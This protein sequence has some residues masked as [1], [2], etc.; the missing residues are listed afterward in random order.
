VWGLD[1]TL[2]R[3]PAPTDTGVNGFQSYWELHFRGFWK[4]GERNAKAKD[5]Q[6]LQTFPRKVRWRLGLYLTDPGVE[7]LR[8]W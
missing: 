5:G 8:G 3:F 4:L 1:L 6:R 7:V 2:D